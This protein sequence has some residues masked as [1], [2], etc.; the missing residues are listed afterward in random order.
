LIAL[1]ELTAPVLRMVSVLLM[2][3]GRDGR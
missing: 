2:N 3:L 1:V